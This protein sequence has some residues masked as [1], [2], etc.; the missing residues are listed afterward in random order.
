MMGDVKRNEKAETHKKI[1]P[2][3]KDGTTNE[4]PDWIGDELR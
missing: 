1:R 4:E 2:V 3:G